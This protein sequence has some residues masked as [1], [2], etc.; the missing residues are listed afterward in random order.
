MIRERVRTLSATE[1]K[2]RFGSV[3]RELA[4]SGGQMLIERDGKPV[5]VI[6]SIETF[7]TTCRPSSSLASDPRV[8]ARSAFG[9]W[10]ACDDIGDGWLAE[11]RERWRSEWLDDSTEPAV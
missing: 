11:S 3:L 8:V 1:A 2:N 4:R 7:E 6:M 10:A 5:A 9:M